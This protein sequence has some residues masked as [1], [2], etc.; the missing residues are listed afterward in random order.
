MANWNEVIVNLGAKVGPQALTDGTLANGR[1]DRTGALVVQQGHG[2]YFEAAIRGRLFYSHCAARAM[3]APAT[4]AIGN[5]VWNPP[6]SGMYLVFGPW[7]VTYLVD[8]ADARA[9]IGRAHV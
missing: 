5:I 8:D 7:D 9:E 2:K 3:S 6:G 1:A 4:S